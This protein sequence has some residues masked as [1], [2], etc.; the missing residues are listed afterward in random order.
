MQ[1]RTLMKNSDVIKKR[2]FSVTV[3]RRLFQNCW[4]SWWFPLL[5]SGCRSSSLS[6]SPALSR[7]EVSL[8]RT[9]PISSGKP[10][11]SSSLLEGTRKAGHVY[12][13]LQEDDSTDM[14]SMKRYFFVWFFI[15]S[16]TKE[17]LSLGQLGFKPGF[18]VFALVLMHLIHPDVWKQET[19]GFIQARLLGPI[20]CQLLL[21][22]SYVN[23]DISY[24][25]KWPVL[26]WCSSIGMNL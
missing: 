24:Q 23:M 6:L 17:K 11:I 4:F 7:R 10:K 19:C 18:I 9:P 2:I 22:I 3:W 1:K 26:I 21:L 15:W 5:A 12:K 13:H 14:D 25:N 20:W 8:F 16:P